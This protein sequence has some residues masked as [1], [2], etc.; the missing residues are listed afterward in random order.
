MDDDH[1]LDSG[2][3]ADLTFAEPQSDIY[4]KVP[5]CWIVTFILVIFIASVPFALSSII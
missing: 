2:G 4:H 3:G 5:P 1:D